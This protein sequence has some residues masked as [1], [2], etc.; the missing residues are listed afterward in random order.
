[1]SWLWL[2]ACGVE[3]DDS[4]DSSPFVALPVGRL[5]RRASLDL[6]GTLPSVAELAR[7]ES[8]GG[9]D[10]LVAEWMNEPAF[11]SNLARVVAEDWLL[12]LDELEVEPLEFGL[13]MDDKFDFNRAFEREPAK[14]VAR[15]VASDRPY[16]EI[17]TADW[18]MAN[19]LLF[20]LVSLEWE[21]E[22]DAGEV[23]RVARYQDGRPPGGVL[24]TSGLWL[25]YHTTIFNFNRGRAAALSRLL[26][27]YEFLTR[28]VLFTEIEDNS[29]DGLLEAVQSDTS[30]LACHSTLDPL[31]S[32]LF[33]FWPFEDKDGWELVNYHPERDG[34]GELYTGSPPAY[35]G[36]ALDGVSQLG[37]MVAEDPRFAMCATKRAAERLWARA[38]DEQDMAA[39]GA[40]KDTF[41]DE[42][43]QYKRLLVAVMESE[44]Y[45]AGGLSASATAADLE[46][47]QPVRTMSP[48][49]LQA[50]IQDTTAFLWRLGG[51]E[52]LTSDRFGYRM[53]LGGADGDTVH[54]VA[55][56]PGLSRMMVIRR[57]A[58]AAAAQVV[59]H[60][61]SVP[62]DNRLL[63]ATTGDLPDSTGASFEA[64]LVRLH[65][66]LHAMEPDVT[67]L[68]EETAH[69]ES[70][71][72]ISD[73]ETA[74]SSVVSLLLR[75]PEFWSY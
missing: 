7:A 68:E 48:H 35:F 67:Q 34:M 45:R 4:V 49:L 72:A 2:L 37:P 59:S 21:S 40:L 16:T 75:D 71:A 64:E 24:M 31:A 27:C 11:E 28:P 51:W 6:R 47:Y 57:V 1:M 70:V 61:S 10:T 9:I 18:T 8:E 42:K 54:A 15:I 43:Y 58:Q 63:L 17:V 39:L 25:R 52:Q 56:E 38:A 66:R 22:A 44:E 50:V 69:W 30:C 32:T 20:S 53:L 23:W 29:T 14:L 12:E 73:V 74:W 3:P 26:L 55:L 65:L 13:S 19:N 41:V 60:D 46:R 36:T 33:G 5:A 62:L